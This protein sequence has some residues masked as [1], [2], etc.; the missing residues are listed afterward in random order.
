MGG[1]KST[2]GRIEFLDSK[3]ECCGICGI[4]FGRAE[5]EVVCRQLGLDF[6]KWAGRSYKYGNFHFIV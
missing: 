5:G 1:K 6:V 4:G 2:E 3:N